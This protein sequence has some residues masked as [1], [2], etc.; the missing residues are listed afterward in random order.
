MYE[1]R[2]LL[3]GV[4][5]SGETAP[6]TVASELAMRAELA[7]AEG[8]AGHGGGWADAVVLYAAEDVRVA[9]L[10]AAIAEMDESL[11]FELVVQVAPSGPPAEPEPPAWLSDALER[12]RREPSL[13]ARRARFRELF[14]RAVGEC[15]PARA[16]TAFL[17]GRDPQVPA[18]AAPDGTLPEALRRCDCEGVDEAA[19]VALGILAGPVNRYPLRTLS[20][21]RVSAPSDRAITAIQSDTVAS[22]V[23]Q[24]A[25]HADPLRVY[26][27]ADA[28]E[29]GNSDE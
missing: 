9:R 1:D 16:H 15:A 13:D 29:A 25:H 10:A 21:R 3:D 4:E 7:S 5:L 14:T 24:L 12:L 28:P 8:H 6:A 17:F 27:P 2:L 23:E 11:R 22:F 20:F 26:F 19:L 18:A